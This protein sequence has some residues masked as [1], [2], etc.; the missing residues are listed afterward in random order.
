MASFTAHLSEHEL[1]ALEEGA[2]LL[3]GTNRLARELRK[4]YNLLKTAGETQVWASP[5]I[6]SLGNWLRNLW[7][8]ELSFKEGNH[9]VL[10]SHS[11]EEAVWELV[12]RNWCEQTGTTLMQFSA[13]ASGARTAYALLH[14]W[15]LPMPELDTHPTDDVR[16]F[17]AWTGAFESWCETNGRISSA[18]LPN[19]VSD[20]YRTGNI[21]PPSVV[22]LA[23]FEEETPAQTALLAALKDSGANIESLNPNK[24]VNRT[25]VVECVTP[26]EE[27]ELCA[28]WIRGLLQSNPDQTIGVIVPD[29]AEQR[30]NI[31]QILED[32]LSPGSILPGALPQQHINIS[33]GPHL[34][35]YPIIATALAALN[36]LRGEIELNQLGALLRSPFIGEGDF[37][38]QTRAL[39]DVRLRRFRER[40]V[41]LSW[42]IKLAGEN[43]KRHSY[44]APRFAKRLADVQLIVDALPSRTG[45]AEWAGIFSKALDE[46][47]WP[48]ERALSSFE[49]QTREKWFGVLDSFAGLE[50][51]MPTMKFSAALNRL[52]QLASS[53]PFQ[54]ATEGA[55]VQVMGFLEAT[56]AQFDALWVMDCTDSQL[57]S[58]AHPHPLLPLQLQ[59]DHRLPHSSPQRE[60]EFA[61][62]RLTGLV[63]AAPEVILSY[64]KVDDDKEN[65]PSPLLQP[66]A[67]QEFAQTN[68][69]HESYTGQIQRSAQLDTVEDTIAPPLGKDDRSRGGVDVLRAQA[70]CPFQAF[71]KHRLHARQLDE[72]SEGL[73]PMAMGSLVHN[74]LERF[75]KQLGSQG[76]LL[77]L[78]SSALN[79]L[80]SSVIEESLEAAQQLHPATFTPQFKEL[81]TSILHKLL[82]GW[83]EQEKQRSAFTV[84]ETEKELLDQKIGDLTI[85]KIIVDRIDELKNGG[86][87]II[88]YKTGKAKSRNAWKGDRPKDPQLPLYTMLATSEIAGVAFGNVSTD[89][90]AW[91]SVS[92]YDEVFAGQKAYPQGRGMSSW[93][94]L[95]P[96]WETLL[97][98]W[99]HNLEFLAANFVSGHAQVDPKSL[100]D[101]CT[102]CH[103]KPACRI[104]ELAGADLFDED[105]EF[106][107]D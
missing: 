66:C 19:L 52:R 43:G 5:A 24:G 59:R 95:Y 62:R 87:V 40:T 6:S 42:L 38:A 99:E 12:I 107:D 65:I 4:E 79:A 39:L 88:D 86:Q 81:Q 14:D 82:D 50:A 85:S 94:E 60:M 32:A 93:K 98:T 13:A 10:L 83:L 76:A 45:A 51:I 97:E 30:V 21:R 69:P 104:A 63:K 23:G 77:R 75:W 61:K 92:Q 100:Q 37:E 33:L 72:A 22:F 15:H 90:P 48:G 36:L 29:L 73:D 34:S 3:T 41:H 55:P 80:K 46:L 47:G 28:N 68:A 26:Q 27:I 54:P 64:A 25:R 106:D 96:D 35:S 91:S 49:Y 89:N 105:E 53:M 102:Y 57:P 74:V 8:D 103:L 70:A 9:A 17:I 78:E 1:S 67:A 71:G 16:A 84:V 44:H 20:G 101:T 18:R 2:L 11:H 31:S 7:Q 56:G 58:L